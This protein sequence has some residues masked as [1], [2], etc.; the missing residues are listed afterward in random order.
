[1]SISSVGTQHS[2]HHVYQFLL[3]FNW[4]FVHATTET[5]KSCLHTNTFE[6]SCSRIFYRPDAGLNSNVDAITESIKACRRNQTDIN[7]R[8][9][10]F[11]DAT[12]KP[13][14]QAYISRRM[15]HQQPRPQ[16]RELHGDGDVGNAV[17][18]MHWMWIVEHRC[19]CGYGDRLHSSTAGAVLLFAATPR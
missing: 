11:M 2:F 3:L 18:G 15:K 12:S 8:C 10:T 6:D 13:S 5:F 4:L 16:T 9:G 1:M 14:S 17:M 7:D 19:V